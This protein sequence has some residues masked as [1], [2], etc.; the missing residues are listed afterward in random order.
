METK[1]WLRLWE[2][3]ERLL[4]VDSLKMIVSR[5]LEGHL[6]GFIIKSWNLVKELITFKNISTPFTYGN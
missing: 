4:R 1:G 3:G 2:K 5:C 6:L